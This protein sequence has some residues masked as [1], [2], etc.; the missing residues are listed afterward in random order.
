MLGSPRRILELK[1]YKL[2]GGKFHLHQN[3]ILVYTVVVILPHCTSPSP[4][5]GPGAVHL[6]TGIAPYLLKLGEMKALGFVAR[7]R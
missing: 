7:W 4:H 5:H 2:T 1:F 3:P 6:M